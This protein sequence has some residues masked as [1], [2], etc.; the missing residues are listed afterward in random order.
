M[1]MCRFSVQIN[2]NINT[3]Y[4]TSD[5]QCRTKRASNIILIITSDFVLTAVFFTHTHTHTQTNKHKH[6]PKCNIIYYNFT[7]NRIIR[8]LYIHT[9]WIV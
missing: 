6:A 8:Y 2:F 9:V 5:Y 1:C 3:N 7:V 4:L